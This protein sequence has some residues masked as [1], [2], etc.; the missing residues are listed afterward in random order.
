MLVYIR[1]CNKR[2]IEWRCFRRFLYI[3]R[4]SWF[5]RQIS[6]VLFC[7]F[8]KLGKPNVIFSDYVRLLAYHESIFI[9]IWVF[10]GGHSH[11]GKSDK[12][13]LISGPDCIWQ[14][15]TMTGAAAGH[16]A[17]FY[18]ILMHPKILLGVISNDGSH[19]KISP[20]VLLVS[21]WYTHL[22]IALNCLLLSYLW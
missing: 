10:A 15:T 4:K 22:F 20:A 21:F 12:L 3:L 1:T 13:R 8:K 9:G 7:I 18:G 14:S 11:G 6:D 2:R 16:S 5:C 17:F 19:L